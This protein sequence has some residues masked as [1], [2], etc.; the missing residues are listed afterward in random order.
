MFHPDIL[1]MI[2]EAEPTMEEF[3]Y[4]LS[5]PTVTLRADLESLLRQAIILD[6]TTA[7]TNILIFMVD[8]A[9]VSTTLPVVLDLLRQPEA[10]I[11]HLLGDEPDDN[12]AIPVLYVLTRNHPSLLKPFLMETGI[13]HYAR[14]IVLILM[15]KI[16][17]FAS[18]KSVRKE[19][20]DTVRSLMIAYIANYKGTQSF[21]DKTSISYLVNTVADAGL[22]DMRDTVVSLYQSG[23]VDESI[24]GD[25]DNALLGIDYSSYMDEII[26]NPHEL[27]YDVNFRL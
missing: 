6:D 21:A 20:A 13:S 15:G 10:M 9:D 8:V 4:V 3:D 17:H 12:L 26:T 27:M 14:Q 23:M 2:K 19:F 24:C 1:P 7:V 22:Y 25:L 5:L 18:D 11:L 16:G